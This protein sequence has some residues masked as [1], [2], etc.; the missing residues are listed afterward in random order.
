MDTTSTLLYIALPIALNSE[1][2][3]EIKNCLTNMK[4]DASFI[5]PEHFHEPLSSQYMH[6]SLFTIYIKDN[7]RLSFALSDPKNS[8][9]MKLTEFVKDTFINTFLIND[10]KK[11]IQLHSNLGDYEIYNSHVAKLYTD[12]KFFDPEFKEKYTQF[13]ENVISFLLENITE[14][15]KTDEVKQYN[16][17]NKQ[18]DINPQY[19]ALNQ[20][21]AVFTHY[22]VDFETYPKSQLAI[23]SWFKDWT[24]HISLLTNNDEKVRNDFFAT[25]KTLAKPP[26]DFLN[27]WSVDKDKF[28][29]CGNKK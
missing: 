12:S 5:T 20:K 17:I 9:F 22:S 6:I 4:Y 27:F 21:P 7:S 28:T 13:R 23:S 10:K 26:M 16:G 24:P 2:G 3:T 29:L 18:E 14:S 19:T 8:I 1:L 15:V 11:V 25:I